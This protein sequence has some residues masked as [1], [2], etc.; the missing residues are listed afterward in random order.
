LERI[1]AMMLPE[2]MAMRALVARSGFEIV[3]N[4]DL[5]AIRVALQL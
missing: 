2:N 3:K 1:T 4:T 5:S